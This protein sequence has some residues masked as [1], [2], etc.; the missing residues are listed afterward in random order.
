MQGNSKLALE[1]GSRIGVI[2][3]GPAGSLFSNF[4]LQMSERVGMDV[5]VD[6]Y[7]G[8]DF[9]VLGPTGCNMSSCII[10][11]PLVQ[12][13]AADGINLPPLVVRRGIDSY[14]LNM[15]VGDVRIETPLHEMRIA[16]VHRGT[17]PRRI[18]ETKGHSFDG[19]LL[20][21]AVERG[22]HLVAERVE[23]LGWNDGRPQVKTKD[24][25]SQVYDLLVVA[26]GV[27]SGVLKLFEEAGLGYKAPV[28]SRGHIW[29]FCLGEETVEKYLG[30]SMHL[31]LPDIPRVDFAC[32]IPKGEFATMV[33]LGHDVDQQ[34]VQTFLNAPE[35][36]ACLSPGMLRRGGVLQ[37]LTADER[38]RSC[39][40]VRRQGGVHRRQWGEQAVQG[41]DGS[42][43]S[44]REVRSS[45]GCLRGRIRR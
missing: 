33:L 22:A 37:L 1:D 12:T 21:L 27:N 8:K 34:V 18:K 17:G 35:V 11:E 19:Y 36:R 39:A 25:S 9:S 26:A 30:S 29:E 28:T 16:A 5:S 20:N 7:E 13:L 14:V 45:D 23:D 24:G 40:A 31:F 32:I 2:G 15:D 6:I 38:P 41:R 10:S 43:L 44:Y 3:G 42:G 4:L